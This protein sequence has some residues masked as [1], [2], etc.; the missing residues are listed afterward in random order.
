[1]TDATIDRRLLT[2][3]AYPDSSNLRARMSI[4]DYKASNV[5]F[6]AWVLAHTDWPAGAVTLDV[7]CGPGNYLARVDGIGIDLSEGMAREARRQAPTVV[8]DVCALPI[9]T[10]SVDRLLAPHMLYHAPDLDHGAAQLRRVLRPGGVALVVT[11]SQRHVGHIVEQLS[12]ATGTAAPVRFIDRF[13]LEN[14]HA[15]LARHFE[16]VE[17]DHLE[18]ELVVPIAQPV[19]A[20]ADSCRALYETQLPDGVTWDAAMAR[21]ATLVDDEI[22][23]HGAWRAVTHSGAFVCR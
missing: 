17:I 20:Y 2:T 1:M 9:A 3:E 6:F 11:N 23:Q 5:D 18:G 19:V 16:H 4:Y 12:A 21:F 8:G 14:G 22:E 7:G 10:A 13:T 15:L